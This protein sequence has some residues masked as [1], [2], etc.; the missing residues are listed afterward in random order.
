M[1]ACFVCVA[2]FFRAKGWLGYAGEPCLVDAKY[3]SSGAILNFLHVRERMQ[4]FY[5]FIFKIFLW[6]NIVFESF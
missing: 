3:T 4:L 5:F 1:N 6:V 2:S